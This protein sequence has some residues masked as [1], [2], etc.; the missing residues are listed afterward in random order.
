MRTSAWPPNSA[1]RLPRRSP[2]RRASD[3]GPGRPFHGEGGMKPSDVSR[4]EAAKTEL[5]SQAARH[6][7]LLAQ[8]RAQSEKTAAQLQAR[9][10]ELSLNSS[11]KGGVL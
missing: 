3:P 11:R 6:E 4:L 10:L 5:S 9:P 1:T 2:G 7:D 8:L